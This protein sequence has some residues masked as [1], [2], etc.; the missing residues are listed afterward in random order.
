MTTDLRALLDRVEELDRAATPGPRAGG[1]RHRALPD[2][3]DAAGEREVAR[4]ARGGSGASMRLWLDDKRPAPWGYDLTAKTADEAIY[5]LETHGPAIEHCSLDHDLA[6]E[7]YMS[8]E[9]DD[10]RQYREK[11]GY[12]VLDWMHETG[13]WCRDIT[14]HSL[15]PRGSED[16]MTKLRNAAPDWV[17]FRRCPCI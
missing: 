9:V 7:H 2:E 17:T 16:M 1:P 3:G 13:R 15:N 8:A 10:R 5:L 14:V 12:S 11:T 4:H 6:D